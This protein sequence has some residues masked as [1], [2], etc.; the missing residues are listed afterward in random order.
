MLLIKLHWMWKRDC[1]CEQTVKT[2]KKEKEERRKKSTT[3][4]NKWT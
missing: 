2:V 3:E 4:Q 1:S